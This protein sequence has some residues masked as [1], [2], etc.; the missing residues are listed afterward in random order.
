MNANKNGAR[1]LD[2]FNISSLKV[3]AKP[4]GPATLMR[5]KRRTPIPDPCLLVFIRG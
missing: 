5:R 4:F 2:R 3:V 1:A